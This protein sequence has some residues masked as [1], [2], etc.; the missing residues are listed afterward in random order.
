MNQTTF[1]M[2]SAVVFGITAILWQERPVPS[3]IAPPR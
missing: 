2:V 1:L 3:S